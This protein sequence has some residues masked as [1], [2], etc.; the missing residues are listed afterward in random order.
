MGA[1]LKRLDEVLSRNMKKYQNFCLKIKFVCLFV[2]LFVFLLLVFFLFFLFFFCF[3]FFC[4][5]FLCGEISKIFE[6]HVS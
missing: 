3:F 1:R 2:C 5:V 6:R 4:F